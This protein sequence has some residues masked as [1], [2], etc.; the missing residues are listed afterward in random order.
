MKV[1]LETKK[2]I[3]S[4]GEIVKT[5]SLTLILCI[6]VSYVPWAEAGTLT[7]KID[8]PG[9]TDSSHIVVHIE[10]AEGRFSPP[11]NHPKMISQDL[12][13]SPPT[14]AV[15]MGTTVDFPNIDPIF[16]SVFSIS[17][18]NPFDLGLYGQE[19]EKFVAF[20]NSGLVEIF[21]HIHSQMHGLI[22]VLENPFFSV[23][24]PDGI[25][26]IKNIPEGNYHLKAWANPSLFKLKPV[27]VEKSETTII[28]FVLTSEN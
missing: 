7:G 21:C 3:F 12:K 2:T 8:I 6:T 5:F 14:L 28:D 18:S 1:L 19:T 16:H 26:T 27:I 22:L 9:K 10:N 25:F 15:M 11:K 4:K 13:F 23:T 17:K 24:T 20:I